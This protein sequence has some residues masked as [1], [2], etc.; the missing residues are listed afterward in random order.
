VLSCDQSV[1]QIEAIHIAAPGS[2]AMQAVKEVEAVA[3]EG[4]AGDRYKE[5]LGFYSARPT[6][7]GARE[8]TLFE[9]ET[10]DALRDES[11]I[12]LSAGEHR[13][14]LT[15]RGVRLDRLLGQRFRV[16]E[17]VLEGVK[18]CPPCEHLAGLVGKPVLRPLVNRGG[19]RARIV[20]GG[21]IRL[22]DPIEQVARESRPGFDKLSMSGNR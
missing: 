16:G 22:G 17:V 14:N 13:R 7:P 18:D 4:L 10:L 1:G 8:V 3:G 6:D 11:G 15:T 21:T 12:A 5:G 20:V 19:L 9:A 2:A